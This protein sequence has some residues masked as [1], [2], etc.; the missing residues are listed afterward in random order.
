MTCVKFSWPPGDVLSGRGEACNLWWPV[1]VEECNKLLKRGFYWRP[2][3][4]HTNKPERNAHLSENICCGHM[5]KTQHFC[6]THTQRECGW[7]LI[8][9]APAQPLNAKP[10]T[11]SISSSPCRFV[12][13]WKCSSNCITLCRFVG[14]RTVTR[15]FSSAPPSEER[16]P[17]VEDMFFSSHVMQWLLSV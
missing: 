16:N 11:V 7:L 3:S 17:T 15:G 2:S 14:F 10:L 9:L 1:A 12:R 13:W 4:A 5:N 6:Q 8:A